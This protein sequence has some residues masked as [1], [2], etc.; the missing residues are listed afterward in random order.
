MKIKEEKKL[1]NAEGNVNMEVLEGKEDQQNDEDNI[2]SLFQYSEVSL[3]LQCSCV[4]FLF[5]LIGRVEGSY[6]RELHYC[7]TFPK[8]DYQ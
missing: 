6:F 7:T 2:E 8:P 5:V 3:S 4:P 1:S